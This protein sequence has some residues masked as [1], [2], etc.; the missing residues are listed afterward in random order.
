[1]KCV[2]QRRLAAF[3]LFCSAAVS[4]AF[5]HM[6]RAEEFF[7]PDCADVSLD[8]IPR[9]WT[10]VT[11]ETRRMEILRQPVEALKSAPKAISTFSAKITMEKRMVPNAEW[12]KEIAERHDDGLYHHDAVI[13]FAADYGQN[14]IYR[15]VEHLALSHT[16][17]GDSADSLVTVD[18]AYAKE[19]RLSVETPREFSHRNYTEGQKVVGGPGVSDK[20]HGFP[21]VSLENL[22]T[23]DPPKEAELEDSTGRINLD[24][25][26]GSVGQQF[27]EWSDLVLHV[28]IID[29]SVTVQDEE[30]LR[31]LQ[32][33]LHVLETTDGEGDKWFRWHHAFKNGAAFDYIWRES[34]GFLPVYYFSVGKDKELHNVKKAQWNRAGGAYAP[35]E[36]IAY[37]YGKTGEP[38]MVRRIRFTDTVVNQPIDPDKFSLKALELP[39]GGII[40]DRVQKKAFE[41]KNGKPVFLAKYGS[42]KYMNQEELETLRGGRAR[43]AVVVLGLAL[44]G[45]G[46]FLR[47]R[48][49]KRR[50]ASLSDR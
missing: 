32:E 49:R 11:D 27:S 15:K 31:G 8:G 19:T 29:G 44:F 42:T 38:T 43:I 41:Y 4:A 23:V 48:R 30:V 35:A 47:L 25:F 5:S 50:E 46:I 39:E 2:Y 40:D 1:M 13:E 17:A 18:S 26:Y 6:T 12:M 33:G 21:S 28:G 3:F 37:Y 36:I 45:A 10:E 16:V 9:E 34:S 24:E 20:I 14:K 22:A 7:V